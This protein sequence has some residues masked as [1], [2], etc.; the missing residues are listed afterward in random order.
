MKV[1]QYNTPNKQTKRKNNQSHDHLI[2]CWKFLTNLTPIHVASIW[3]S[4]DTGHIPKHNQSNIWY[5]IANIKLNAEK[6]KAIPL[7]SVT[8][9]PTL[10]LS[11]QYHTWSSSP[12]NLTT[13]ANLPENYYLRKAYS[14]K[15]IDTKLTKI[16][17]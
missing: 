10:S 12:S 16:K 5:S 6:L 11:N 3:E 17:E 7:K 2:R 15:W 9:L 4:I 8:R 13:K 1:H 14:A